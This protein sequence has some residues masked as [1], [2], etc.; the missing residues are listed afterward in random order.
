MHGPSRILLASGNRS[1][2]A[3]LALL[4]EPLGLQLLSPADVGGLPEVEEDQPSFALNARKKAL[5]AA[6]ASGE[7]ALA[8]DSGLEV[9]A[10]GGEPGVR[11]ARFAGPGADDARNN[12]LLLQRLAA[13]PAERRAARFVCALALA[14]PG[15][16]GEPPRIELAVHGEVRGRILEEA[17][18]A[19]GFG[20]DPLFL[21]SEEGAPHAGRSFGELERAQ[22]AAVS[23]RGRALARLTHELDA[24]L[25]RSR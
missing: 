11:S 22:K 10:L 21:L 7:W 13:V 18:G 17:R 5:S 9:E 20:Y 4:L 25:R 15:A 3:E 8:D 14:R 1:K 2:L 24:R 19:G 12:A 6:A 23:H 16:A